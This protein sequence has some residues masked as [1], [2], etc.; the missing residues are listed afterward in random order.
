M[1]KLSF[2]IGMIFFI[3]IILIES[4][5]FIVLYNNLANERVD[6]IMQSLLAR[7]NTHRDVLEDHYDDS[8][9]EHVGIMESQSQFTV[10]IIDEV[11]ELLV[12]SDPLEDDM[13]DA[14]NHVKN[15]HI[16]TEGKIVD[17]DWNTGTYI[18]TDSPIEVDGTYKGHVLMFADT[19]Y[20]AK[21]VKELSK[22]FI[23][24]GIVTIILTIIITYLLSRFVTEPLIK[25][26]QATEQMSQGNLNVT[27]KTDRQDELGEL[28]RSITYLA[29][30]LDRMKKSRNEFLASIS[31]E[32]RTP[33]TYI[34][35]YADILKRS[36]ISEGEKDSYV[37]IIREEADHLADFIKK[38]F[39]LAKMDEHQFKVD[40]EK[41]DLSAWLQDMMVRLEPWI[42]EADLNLRLDIA[43][44]LTANLDTERFQQVVQNIVDNA[45]KHSENGQTIE[46]KAYEIDDEL[47]LII[48]DEGEGIAK[49]DLPFIFDRL[50]RVEKSRSRQSGG[51]GLGLAICKEIVEAH[52]GKI[53][54][55]SKKGEGTSLHIRLDKGV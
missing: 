19:N 25:M 32:L 15:E 51:A 40:R 52:R 38:L 21:P 12:A 44:N 48:R 39:E 1:T 50:Y 5:L 27:L 16:P 13:Y 4:F 49:D 36:D 11:G 30:D 31:H 2:K 17:A 35:G 29:N 20:V 54:I 47:H 3:A 46:L 53:A 42:E 37:E 45:I 24:A 33:L 43:G 22:Q 7:G 55:K 6:E 9:L 8:T 10:V 18:A 41:I 34:K 28:A 26:K 23:L 14:I